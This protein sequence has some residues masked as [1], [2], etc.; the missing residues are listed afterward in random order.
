MQA[1]DWTVLIAYFLLMVGVGLW[2]RTKVVDARDF[3][4][5]GGAM[6]WWLSGISHHMSGYSSAVFVGYAAL[7]Y[8][9]GFSLYVWWACSISLA[10]VLGAGVFAPRWARLR[11]QFNLISPL[12]FLATRYGVPTQQVLAWSGAVLKIFDVGAKWTS[13]ALLLNAFAGVPF[14]WG[15][16]LTGGVTLVYAVVGGLWADALTDLSQ[17][18]IQI[19]AG[20]AM[21][22]AALAR[23]G[24]VSGLWTVW[25]RLPA[26][27]AH[28]F[29]GDYTPWFAL[30]FLT[31]STLSYNGGTWNLAQRF[32]AS[33]SDREARRAALLSSA[34]YLLW[35]P[36]LLFPMWAAP[37]LLPHL[38]D[39]GE[40]YALLTRSLLPDGL[41]GLV[42]AGL[43][44]HTMAMTS[45]DANAVSAVVVRDILPVLRRGAAALRPAQELAAGRIATFVFLATSMVLGMVADRFGGVMGLILLWYGALVG[46]I[47][48]PMLLGLLPAFRRCGPVAAMLSVLAG[49]GAF[50]GVKFLFAPAIAALPGAWSM[51]AVVAGPVLASLL[52]YVGVGLA[53]G[54]RDPASDAL[55][56]QLNPQSSGATAPSTPSIFGSSS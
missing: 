49:A 51:T 30:A 29:G 5:A 54:W 11:Q 9:Q 45:S 1:L 16:L 19:V 22:V 56:D 25:D 44:A 21:L 34:L 12:E 20:V 27:H 48:V 4:T 50:V 52:V 35:P 6:P 28:A 53:E 26:S 43:F 46:P 7:A 42:L 24:G 39:P 13:A 31:V 36:V 37:V 23:L 2:A 10:L 18:L 40:S 38:A 47:A 14:V 15:V 55:L 33:P 3:F 41:V 8:T 17:F 32:M